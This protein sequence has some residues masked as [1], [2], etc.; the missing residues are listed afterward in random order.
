MS[1]VTWED[2]IQ[3]FQN[4]YPGR[5]VPTSSTIWMLILKSV[6]LVAR[7]DVSVC[8]SDAIECPDGLSC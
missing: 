6:Q 2:T 8:D 3:H 5:Q 1:A 7:Y 4:E